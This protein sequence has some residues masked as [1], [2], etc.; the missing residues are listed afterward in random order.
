PPSRL[1]PGMPPVPSPAP[2]RRPRLA[3]GEP[4]AGE[5]L[6]SRGGRTR[7]WC[8]HPFVVRFDIDNGESEP[9]ASSSQADELRP[10]GGFSSFCHV[11]C[12]LAVNPALSLLG[13]SW[14]LAPPE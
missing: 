5:P 8:D 10:C 2:M 7:T 4:A 14:T 1:P 6:S 12:W 13:R 9:D 3:A 11:P